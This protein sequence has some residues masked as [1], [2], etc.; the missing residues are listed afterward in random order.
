LAL[1]ANYTLQFS[2]TT[3]NIPK[4]HNATEYYK[5]RLG[6]QDEVSTSSE[7]RQNIRSVILRID[8]RRLTERKLRRVC[9]RL[10]PSVVSVGPAKV[11]QLRA[12]ATNILKA[13]GDT[14][15]FLKRWPQIKSKIVKPQETSAF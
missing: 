6:T 7:G 14:G 4:K 5:Q 13:K 15:A 11:K 10:M 1:V 2:K 3:L 12:M 8:H 9:C